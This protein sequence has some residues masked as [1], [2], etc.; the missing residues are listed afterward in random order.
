MSE[1]KELITEILGWENN[2]LF[3]TLKGLTI[4]PAKS[5]WIFCNGDK[6]SYIHP[7]SYMFGVVGMIVLL[8]TY[9]EPPYLKDYQEWEESKYQEK[10]DK[11]DSDSDRYAVEVKMHQQEQMVNKILRHPNFIYVYHFLITILHLLVFRKMNVGLKNNVWFTTYVYAHA[12][13][14]VSVIAVLL[15]F[16]NDINL[17]LI[18]SS[19][20]FLIMYVYRVWASKQFYKI[21]WGKSIYKVFLIYFIMILI[22]VMIGFVTAI[23]YH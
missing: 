1:F 10:L 20:S 15:F 8:N 22:P 2:K 7:I 13:L 4:H 9:F 14:L 11:L 12:S 3:R 19:L 23:V 6:N 16:I 21:S 18:I 5:I 17:V